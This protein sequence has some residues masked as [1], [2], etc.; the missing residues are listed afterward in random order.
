[1]L[2]RPQQAMTSIFQPMLK[3]WDDAKREKWFN[4]ILKMK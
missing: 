1:M 4:I 2:S 3:S